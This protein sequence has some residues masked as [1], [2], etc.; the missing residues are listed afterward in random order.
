MP[1]GLLNVYD[2]RHQGYK[3][4]I[5]LHERQQRANPSA[6]TGSQHAKLM[7]AVSPQ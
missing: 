3:S 6:V 1:D 7:A 2:R 4:E 5:A